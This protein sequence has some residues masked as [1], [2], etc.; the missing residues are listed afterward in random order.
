MRLPAL[1]LGRLAM[2][3]SF[4]GLLTTPQSTASG[5]N[6]VIVDEAFDAM[7]AESRS[8]REPAECLKV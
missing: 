8:Y 5:H 1:N 4:G 6:N 7:H 2:L 3:Q